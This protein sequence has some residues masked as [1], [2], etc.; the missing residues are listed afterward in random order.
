LPSPVKND[1]RT[2]AAEERKVTG[3]LVF[4]AWDRLAVVRIGESPSSGAT[5]RR[6]QRRNERNI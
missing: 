6:L 2:D 4:A 3:E 1:A 5:K